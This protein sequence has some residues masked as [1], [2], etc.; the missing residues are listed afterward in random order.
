MPEIFVEIFVKTQSADADPFYWKDTFD[1][2]QSELLKALDLY[3]GRGRYFGR[4]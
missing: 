3:C 4:L 1:G 2:E